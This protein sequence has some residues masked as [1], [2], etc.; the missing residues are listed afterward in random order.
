MGNLGGA[1]EA[2][3]DGSR[4]LRITIWGLRKVFPAQMSAP[5]ARGPPCPLLPV[6]F[7][8]CQPSGSPESPQQNLPRRA[9]EGCPSHRP[10]RQPVASASLKG[11]CWPLASQREEQTT[12]RKNREKNCNLCTKCVSLRDTI[13]GRQDYRGYGPAGRGKEIS[14]R[15]GRLGREQS[16]LDVSRG[17]SCLHR[18][19]PE[20]TALLAR[21]SLPPP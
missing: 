15:K 21:P 2:G 8:D 18:W 4:G 14:P 16:H 3:G 7:M 1:G 9:G 11:V 20:I 10:A 13:K 19:G 6:G 17:R 12:K 5:R